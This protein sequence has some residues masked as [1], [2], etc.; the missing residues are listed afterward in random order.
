MDDGVVLTVHRLNQEIVFTR[1]RAGAHAEFRPTVSRRF[2]DRIH[3]RSPLDICR[4]GQNQSLTC[5]RR[6]PGPEIRRNDGLAPR[7]RDPVPAV[8]LD[9]RHRR[10]GSRARRTLIGTSVDR[11]QNRLAGTE[12]P[13]VRPIPGGGRKRKTILLD[14]RDDFSRRIRATREQADDLALLQRRSLLSVD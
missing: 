5:H 7:R 2:R 13:E 10:S 9:S 12:R 1:N 6:S 11:I 3:P 14:D 4:A 8:E